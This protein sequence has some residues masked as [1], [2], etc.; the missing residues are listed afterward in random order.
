MAKHISEYKSQTAAYRRGRQE[1]YAESVSS[2]QQ[3]LV[4]LVV[5]GMQREGISKS[6][7]S[8]RSGINPNTLA[9]L[10]TGKSHGHIDTWDA[11]INAVRPKGESSGP[12]KVAKRN[13]STA[14]GSVRKGLGST[15]GRSKS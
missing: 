10:M 3:L 15:R 5:N 2:L 1:K 8:K 4:E 13:R 9:K 6:E 11:L 7:L 12:S 14:K